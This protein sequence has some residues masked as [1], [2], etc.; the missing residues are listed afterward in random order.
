MY[1]V[2]E[3]YLE[4]V[5]GDNRVFPTR[6]KFD[7]IGGYF[8]N[9][10][11]RSGTYENI[12]DGNSILSMGNACANKIEFTIKGF[13]Q[14]FA[15]KGARFTA[16]KGLVVQGSIVWV[17]WGTFW[18][19]DCRTSNIQ[20]TVDIVGYDFMYQLS[21]KDYVT[22]LVAPFHYRDWL[23]EFL[24]FTGLALRTNEEL[25]DAADED[26]IIP[27][28]PSG[29][30]KCSDIAGHLA[31]MLVCNARIPWDD[32][33]AIEFTWWTPTTTIIHKEI[34]MGG[35]EKLADSPL[36]VDYLVVKTEKEEIIIENTDDSTDGAIDFSEVDVPAEEDLPMFTFVFDEENQTASVQLTDGYES[37][38]G[39][40]SI[41]TSV[42]TKGVTY[43]VTSIPAKGF[44]YSKA[45][46]IYL[47]GKLETI[48]ERA[49]GGCTGITEI[50]I[51]ESVTSLA[52]KAFQHCTNLVK[53]YLNAKEFT[54]PSYSPFI[55]VGD[56]AEVIVG[57]SC[58]IIP[59]ECFRETNI[60]SVV[61]GNGVKRIESFAFSKCTKLTSVTFGSGLEV[62]AQ[63]A[64]NG[65]SG[66][67][68][69]VIPD[70]VTTIDRWAFQNCTGLT[71]VQIGESA[72][73]AISSIGSNS[74]KN[75]T[76]IE[77]ISIYAEAGSVANSPWGATNASIAWV[78]FADV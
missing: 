43:T 56:G 4:V 1:E 8:T 16:E 57:D 75:D 42:T 5:R 46:K 18:V 15:W 77:G 34:R 58:T 78:V 64:F 50:T 9:K 40:V 67:T 7:G 13:T 66:L 20:R 28:W 41:P 6:I 70:S 3:A 39:A 54:C 29:V 14:P 30:Y 61:F 49:F 38:E 31:G 2:S 36:C 55:S 21:K 23:D 71:Y 33:N 74:F 24:S 63:Y 65:C 48:G 53:I 32:P 25:P 62:I 10:D 12:I 72:D 73:C 68:S 35:F 59:A 44:E 60:G 11:L 19:T 52:Y 76:N 37:Y 47:P 26:Y 45:T 27:E 17:P 69:L 51:P 22:S